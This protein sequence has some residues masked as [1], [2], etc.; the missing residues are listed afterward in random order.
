MTVKIS[1]LTPEKEYIEFE[2]KKQF[3][4]LSRAEMTPQEFTR[5][6]MLR[7]ELQEQRDTLTDN[8]NEGQILEA[9]QAVDRALDEVLTF[10][11]PGL[12]SETL[13]T[14]QM[15]Q[16]DLLITHWSK[17]GTDTPNRNGRAR[18]K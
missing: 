4:F 16:K 10:I 14:V 8:E 1:S 5:L 7:I 9:Y 12:D 17:I 2:N 18:A 15:G 3:A 11:M 6:Q 13:A